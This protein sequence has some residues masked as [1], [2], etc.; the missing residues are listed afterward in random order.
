[1]RTL[2]LV[3][4]AAS[5]LG[6]SIAMMLSFAGGWVAPY[7]RSIELLGL[8]SFLALLLSTVLL[9]VVER[10]RKPQG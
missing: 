8:A 10:R 2:V 5:V 9:V 4:M 6:F 1:M 3:L 7:A